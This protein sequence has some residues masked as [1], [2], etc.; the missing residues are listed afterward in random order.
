MRWCDI[1]LVSDTSQSKDYVA[2]LRDSTDS[3]M[4]K[5]MI[6]Q[7]ACTRATLEVYCA[8]AEECDT[9]MGYVCRENRCLPPL[10]ASRRVAGETCDQGAANTEFW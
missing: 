5:G 3:A 4:C 8:S 9:S 7:L 1:L 10:G 6:C 2:H